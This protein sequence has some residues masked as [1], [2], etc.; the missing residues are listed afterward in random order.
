[1]SGSWSI[2]KARSVTTTKLQTRSTTIWFRLQSSFK[3]GLK[4]HTGLSWRMKQM[5]ANW[6]SAWWN[7]W[8]SLNRVSSDIQL[9]VLSFLVVSKSTRC[10]SKCLVSIRF[11]PR[12]LL[13]AMDIHSIW[14]R[15]PI[16]WSKSTVRLVVISSR[17][18][19][20]NP[21]RRSVLCSLVLT[22]ATLDQTQ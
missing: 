19:S 15:P 14:A 20:L 22:Y 3:S 16:F 10:T 7:S 9:F 18:N 21:W 2:R 12:L 5:R 8:W 11:L 4:S 6:S 1:M 17:W 13:V